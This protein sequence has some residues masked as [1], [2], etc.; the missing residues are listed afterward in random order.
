MVNE[1]SFQCDGIALGV[2]LVALGRTNRQISTSTQIARCSTKLLKPL[3]AC[4][5]GVIT[6]AGFQPP[7]SRGPYGCSAPVASARSPVG[8]MHTLDQRNDRRPIKRDAS[9]EDRNS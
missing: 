6:R 4:P 8:S 2:S 9:E 3:A 1:S 5:L 7:A